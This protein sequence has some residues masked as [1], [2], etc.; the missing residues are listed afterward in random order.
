MSPSRSRLS[1]SRCGVPL[2]DS[3][4]ELGR[5]ERCPGCLVRTKVTLF[6]AY[7]RSLTTAA[8]AGGMAVSEGEAT[9]FYHAQ[10]RAVAL[11]DGCGRFLCG[12]CNM[13]VSPQHFCP[14][15]LESLGNQGR[16]QSLERQRTRY[17]QIVWSLLVVPAIIW[18]VAVVTAPT[19]LGLAL[20]KWKSAESLVH[21][22]RVSLGIAIPL[23]LTEIGL[24]LTFWI[25]LFSS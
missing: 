25:L 13:E 14:S 23:A 15:C 8:G 19:A 17:D 21:R 22:P 20:W 10:K 18:P 5:L 3:P 2:P 1:C 6:P 12:L 4:D 16:I 24:T 9:C 11:C 7:H